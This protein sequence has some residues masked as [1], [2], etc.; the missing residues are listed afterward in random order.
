MLV[1]KKDGSYRFCMDY[2]KLNAVTRTEAFPLPHIDD[3]LDTLAGARYFSTLD[4]ASG[5]WQVAMG[6][7]SV[8]K[9]TFATTREPTSSE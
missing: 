8:A 7:D 9:T 5:F 3:Y 6:A 2:C 1:R 4:L